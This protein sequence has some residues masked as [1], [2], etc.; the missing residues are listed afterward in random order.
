ME[1]GQPALLTVGILDFADGIENRLT[2]DVQV[3]IP[4]SRAALDFRPD[5]RGLYT[6]TFLFAMNRARYESL[7]DD[8][9]RV[10]DDNAGA[11]LARRIGRE[12]DQAE[13]IGRAEAVRLGHAFHF[14]EGEEL[15]RWREATGPV[16]DAWV[17]EMDERGHDG[18][19]LLEA[20]RAL[21]RKY[22]GP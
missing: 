13:R 7:P 4:H 18:R 17:K 12:W 14:V 11:N 9:K 8:L 10:I 15:A 22:S 2:V 3:L 16:I 5:D 1:H 20:A 21:V 19:M 6:A